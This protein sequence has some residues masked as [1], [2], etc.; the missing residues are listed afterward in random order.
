MNSAANASESAESSE[1]PRPGAFKRFSIPSWAVSVAF[2]AMLIIVCGL[3]FR[4]TPRGGATETVREVGITLAKHDEQGRE[5]YEDGGGSESSDDDSQAESDAA[6]NASGEMFTD[7]F[8]LDPGADLPSSDLP[9]IGFG[10]GEKGSGGGGGAAAMLSG[11][12]PNKGSGGKA[13]TSVFTVEG[14][15]SSFI[16]VFDRSGSMGGP[17]RN[18]LDAAKAQ[19]MASLDALESTHRFQIIF[20]NQQP[21][22]FNP[23]GRGRLPFA[24]DRVKT[25]A[26]QFIHGVT[27]DGNTDHVKALQLALSMSP[28]VIFFLT[29][30]ERPQLNGGQ[31]AEIR[32]RNRGTAIHAIEFGRG[33]AAPGTNQ[34]QRL[35]SENRGNYG[36]VDVLDLGAN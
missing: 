20:Y 5:Y 26:R 18:A 9:A 3:L 22:L 6:N 8:N 30:A 12:G 29:D 17:G 7:D 28:E 4:A 32:R 36:Y 2:H 10:G 15:G 21:W 16:Y 35:A 13:K 31:F 24:S 23:G 33:P 34:L 11:S 1:S 19:L 14:E 25:Q 27:A